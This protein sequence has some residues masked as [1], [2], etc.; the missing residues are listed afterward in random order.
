MLILNLCLDA[1]WKNNFF[2]CLIEKIFK[3]DLGELYLLGAW[4]VLKYVNVSQVP[5]YDQFSKCK[6]VLAAY[7]ALFLH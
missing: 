7:V 6:F 3:V 1:P 2:P 4:I 5:Y